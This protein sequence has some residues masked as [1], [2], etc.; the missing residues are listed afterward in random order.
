VALG[1]AGLA[2]LD[3]YDVLDSF[4]ASPGDPAPFW[5]LVDMMPVPFAVGVFLLLLAWHLLRKAR[6][7]RRLRLHGLEMVAE[8]RAK[9]ETETMVGGLHEYQVD[10][11][12]R[13]K[14]RAPYDASTKV[15]LDPVEAARLAIG[16]TVFVR[17]DPQNPTRV[18][19]ETTG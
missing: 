7:A 13:P 3:Y 4:A 19:I 2:L 15:L 17:V 16:S 10:L 11:S 8:V 12:V 14:N 6:A 5:S 9:S 1:W 18:L